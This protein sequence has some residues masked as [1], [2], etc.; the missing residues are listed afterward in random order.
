MSLCLTSHQDIIQGFSK[1][2]SMKIE[3]RRGA[4]DPKKYLALPVGTALV[5]RS[6][7]QMKMIKP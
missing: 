7:L 6:F 4:V 2:E 1:V 5:E 3:G